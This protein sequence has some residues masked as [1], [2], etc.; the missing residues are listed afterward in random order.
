MEDHTI[1]S[2]CRHYP[3]YVRYTRIGDSLNF[4]QL[5][6][7]IYVSTASR[8][9]LQGCILKISGSPE[10]KVAKCSE[11]RSYSINAILSNAIVSTALVTF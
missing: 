8:Y 7:H 5:F 9:S 4:N 11:K 6:P 3:V 1:I 2:F 10:T